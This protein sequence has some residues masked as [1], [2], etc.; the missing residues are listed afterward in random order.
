MADAFERLVEKP[1]GND[2][3]NPKL[4]KTSFKYGPLDVNLTY[5]TGPR[6]MHK[7]GG[8]RDWAPRTF[9]LRPDRRALGAS[10]HAVCACCVLAACSFH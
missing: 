8:P 1:S 9:S 4:P 5:W 10:A 3:E 7:T 6:V 2:T